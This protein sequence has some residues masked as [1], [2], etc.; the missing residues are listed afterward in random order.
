MLK[1]LAKL[2]DSRL[3]VALAVLLIGAGQAAAS[4][5]RSVRLGVHPD[6]TRVVLDLSSLT[7]FTVDDG[8]PNLVAIELTDA[9]AA[10]MGCSFRKRR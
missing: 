8:Q 7:R 9:A 2:L 5:V 3:V 6:H 4:D 10:V 1:L